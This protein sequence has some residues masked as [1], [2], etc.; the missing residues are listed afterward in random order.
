MVG[1]NFC[2][3][4]A[5]SPLQLREVNAFGVMP[6]PLRELEKIPSGS[7]AKE[8]E[9]SLIYFGNSAGESLEK[10]EDLARLFLAKRKKQKL[11][12]G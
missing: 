4:F 2:K 6:C 12:A 7:Y 1:E 5:R 10:D 9:R 3:G 8:K 11:L